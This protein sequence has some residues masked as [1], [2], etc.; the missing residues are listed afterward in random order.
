MLASLQKK[1]PR[2]FLSDDRLK[3][4]KKMAEE[5][6][7]LSSLIG[8]VWREADSLI[9]SEP[10]PFQITGPRMLKNCQQILNRVM[11]LS[12]VY[13]LTDDEKY[14]DRV[15]LELESAA[16]F[17]HWN[18]DHF[19]D[20][21]ELCTAFAVAYDWLFPGLAKDELSMIRNT[22]LD[23]GLKVGL[24]QYQDNAWWLSHRFNWN[25]V[26]HGG[27][28]IGALALA[29]EEPELAE[30]I[31]SMTMD[32][33][34]ISLAN[35]APDGAWQA[36]P[37]YWEYTTWYTSLLIDALV[38]ALRHDFE[39][40]KTK[41]LEKTGFFRIHCMG[42]VSM[43]FN[44]ADAS[45]DAQA[46]PVLYWLGN[47]YKETQLIHENRRL[48]QKQLSTGKA[49]HPF[50]IVWYQ[51]NDSPAVELPKCAHFK[52]PETVFMRGAWNDPNA[53]FIGF[54]GGL[55]QADH[56]HL[57]LGSFVF[58][59]KGIRWVHDLGRDDYDLAGYW[60]D[61]EGGTRWNIYRLNNKSHNTLAINN[62]LQ[63]AEAKAPIVKTHFTE[64]KCYAI[65]DLS[66]AY[67]PHV[68]QV[69]RGI[70]LV[71]SENVVIQDEI[72]W[73]S[74]NKNLQWHLTTEAEI[75]LDGAKAVLTENGLKMTA[76]ILSPLGSVFEIRSVHRDLPENTNA[77]FRQLMFKYTETGESTI[78]CVVLSPAGA[79][80]KLL[81]LANW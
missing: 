16:S 37:D 55:N 9:D 73:A 8:H 21:A 60:D 59:A 42:P 64:N 75:A 49:V 10:T 2:L 38:T 52:G 41:G 35:Y 81:R 72:I 23:K 30:A 48:L 63:R 69:K 6:A 18:P 39:L 34:P 46:S 74:R 53:L 17:P 43:V 57:D 68:K 11:T 32:K 78:I 66:K 4:L 51:P 31:L 7:F 67:H 24:Q 80:K 44:F 79:E 33:L 1:H 58:D 13:R 70:A 47:K 40:L 76:Q 54:K 27:L 14:K 65:A 3:A 62:D 25:N 15:I 36:G 26:C 29:D 71:D 22:L 19:L 61:K 12:L 5:D 20:T 50:N 45:A 28:A 56:G 77:G